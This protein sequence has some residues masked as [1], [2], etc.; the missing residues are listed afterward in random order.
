MRA[1]RR[2]FGSDPGTVG[3]GVTL[4]GRAVAALRQE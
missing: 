4:D 3:K 2:R 1:W